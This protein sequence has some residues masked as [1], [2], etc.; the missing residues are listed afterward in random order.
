M[1]SLP[2]TLSKGGDVL[3]LGIVGFGE[4]K[5]GLIR[6]KKPQDLGRQIAEPGQ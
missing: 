4:D 1:Q 2:D 5:T 3:I 6:R